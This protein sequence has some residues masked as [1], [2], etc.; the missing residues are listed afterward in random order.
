MLNALDNVDTEVQKQIDMDHYKTAD[1]IP[2]PFDPKLIQQATGY[3]QNTTTFK[4]PLTSPT[5]APDYRHT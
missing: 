3:D 4:P 1:K 5:H 2:I